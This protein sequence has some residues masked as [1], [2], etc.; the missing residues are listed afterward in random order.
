[1]QSQG[2]RDGHEGKGGD[3]DRDHQRSKARYGGKEAYSCPSTQARDCNVREIPMLS[4]FLQR[5]HQHHYF[6]PIRDEEDSTAAETH[7]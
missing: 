1:M 4:M 7:R 5:L 3:R 6:P 2:G